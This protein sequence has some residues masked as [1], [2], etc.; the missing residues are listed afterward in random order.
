VFSSASNN[1]LPAVARQHVIKEKLTD[2]DFAGHDLR[3]EERAAFKAG[4]IFESIDLELLHILSNRHSIGPCRFSEDVCFQG[5][6]G[7]H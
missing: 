3:E 4:D 1:V 5:P 6:W 7:F 2:D